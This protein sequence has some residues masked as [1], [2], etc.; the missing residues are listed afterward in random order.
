MRVVVL[1]AERARR[2]SAS[3]SGVRGGEVVRVQV[4]GDHRGRRSRS[5]RRSA[6]SPSV[7]A[8][9][10]LV[11]LQVADV[12]AT[13]TRA[14]PRARQNVLFSSAPQP[15]TGRRQPA[16]AAPS[17]S[18]AYP[19]DRRSGSGRAARRPAAPS[20]R[21]GCGSAGR[22]ARKASAMPASRPAR[23]R[24]GRRSARRRRCRW[25]SPAARPSRGEQQV[26]QRRV[27]QHQPELARLPGATAGGDRRAAARR[28]SSTIGRAG[29][30]A[31][32][33]SAVVDA[34]TARGARGEV[35]R[36]SRANGFSSRCLRARSAATAAS[37]AASQARW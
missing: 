8:A 26:V 1:H 27:R 16:T 32:P 34:R 6:R 33:R 17:G 18:G 25:S 13:G 7:Y 19:R 3:S 15:S 21:R 10:R 4:V 9:Q 30:R 12:V 24:R 28:G 36:P 22:G 37:S 23:R 20:R 2:R 31:A 14:R 11:V 35:A 5:S 29:R